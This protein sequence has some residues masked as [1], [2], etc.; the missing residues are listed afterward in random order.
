MDCHVGSTAHHHAIRFRGRLV[1]G[2]SAPLPDGDLVIQT[3]ADQRK[4]VVLGQK[5]SRVH[6]TF[7][8]L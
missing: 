2:D 3:S 5:E 8:V 1:G 7:G 6:S 4:M